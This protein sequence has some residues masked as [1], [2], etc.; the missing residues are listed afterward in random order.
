MFKQLFHRQET[1][2]ENGR[3]PAPVSHLICLQGATKP[4]A[5]PAGGF[6]ALCHVNLKIK[7]GQFIADVD[8]STGTTA[9]DLVKPL[10]LN[11]K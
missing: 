2:G 1:G 4:F 8:K 11:D 7:Q 10:T 6:P 5:T 9:G 3:S